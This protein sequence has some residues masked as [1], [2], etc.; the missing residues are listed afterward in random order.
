MNTLHIGGIIF[1]SAAWTFIVALNV[2]CI[3]KILRENPKKIVD[4]QDIESGLD[5]LGR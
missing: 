3:S 4:T 2:F 5:K 1:M